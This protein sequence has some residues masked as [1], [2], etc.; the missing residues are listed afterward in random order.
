MIS[1]VL[2]PR[3]GGVP[4]CSYSIPGTSGAWAGDAPHRGD[5]VRHEATPLPR[6][7]ERRMAESV[8]DL[9][10]GQIHLYPTE[11][12]LGLLSGMETLDVVL[13]NATFA[14]VRLVGVNSASP[15]GTALSG[16]RPGVLPP[17]GALKGLLTVLPSGP[18]QQDTTYTFVTDI[19]ERS[20][21]IT[22]SRLLLFPF[23]PDWSDGLEIDYAFDTV[24][25]RG[26]NGDEQRRPLAKRPL[27]TLRATIWGDGVNG[28]R[29]HHLVQYGKD[30]VFGVPL[31]QEALDVAD[32]DAARQVLTPGRD[33]GDCWNLTRLCDLIMLHERRSGTFMACSLLSKDPA[34]R[35]L[36]VAAPVPDVFAEGATRLVPLFTGILTSAE[37]AVVSDGMK[38]W[39]VEFRELAGSQPALGAL[40]RVP[41]E[42]GAWLWPHRPDWSGDGVGGTSSLL[43]TLRTVRG[44]VMELGARRDVAPS[45]HRQKYLLR[46]PELAGLLDRATALRGRW[47]ALLVRDPRRCFTL[48][49]GAAADKAI[50]YVLDNGAKDG[51]IPNQRLWIALPGGDVLNRRLVAVEDAGVGELALHLDSEPGVAVPP[52]SRV[53]REYYARLDTDCVT[54]RHESAGVSRCELSFH[55][56]PEES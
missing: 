32:I 52:S 22:A 4:E 17:T 9:I 21:T 12:H 34:G 54:V 10:Y 28:Q 15:A 46:E 53:G 11:A 41:S 1:E 5:M 2:W 19:G 50:L 39:S 49:R 8:A 16:F 33:F 35:T 25:T 38:T 44:G 14:P 6:P 26:E 20:L 40:P 55:T 30:R 13:W 23:W 27:R 24:L 51:F 7:S 47:K 18:A 36:S 56:L 48:T 37:P 45:T 3:A 42:S 29:L 43:R 31:W